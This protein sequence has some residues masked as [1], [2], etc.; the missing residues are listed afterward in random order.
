MTETVIKTRGCSFCCRIY[1][2]GKPFVL[3]HGAASDMDMFDE[4]AGILSKHC[5]VILY[6]RRGY[7]M[8]VV[9]EGYPDGEGENSV[10]SQTEDLREILKA[11]AGSEKAY[12]LGF[13]AGGLVALELADKYPEMV[14]KLFL[15]ETAY[16]LSEATLKGIDD[17]H[18]IL[19][20]FAEKN[21]M[22][23]AMV[24]FVDAIGGS[25]PEGQ[26]TSLTKLKENVKNLERFLYPELDDFLTYA[27]KN[28]DIRLRV[29]VSVAAG[30]F[31]KGTLFYNGM[32]EIG[33]TWD[34]DL[35]ILEGYHNLPKDRPAPFADWLLK[36]I[37][38]C[39]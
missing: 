24:S 5:R 4:L 21:N 6:D 31:D 22:A 7:S 28:P 20:G 9:D 13:S 15:Y 32:N 2:E 38:Q 11:L 39:P 27:R 33:T 30:K 1:G 19:K 25:D 23:K 12:V 17:R 3:V 18:D 16:G 8:S 10:R 34:A 37:P 29:P 35:T 36:N 14:E 26:R